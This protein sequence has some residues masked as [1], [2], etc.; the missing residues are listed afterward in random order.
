M[1]QSHKEIVQIAVGL[2]VLLALGLFVRGCQLAVGAVTDARRIELAA[3]EC[4]NAGQ[5][6]LLIRGEVSCRE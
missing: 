5:R 4:T 6:A 3:N 2:L 1:N